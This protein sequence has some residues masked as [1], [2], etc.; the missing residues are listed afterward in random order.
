MPRIPEKKERRKGVEV[1]RSTGLVRPDRA[2]LRLV[3]MWVTPEVQTELML[4]KVKAR[5]PIAAVVS[6]LV[7]RYLPEWLAD[8]MAKASDAAA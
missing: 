4:A 2:G 1:P 8:E 6:E 7:N 3:Q 5:K